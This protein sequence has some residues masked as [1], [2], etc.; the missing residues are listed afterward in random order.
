MVLDVQRL[1]REIAFEECL[2]YLQV[3]MEEHKFQPPMGEKTQSVLRA[4]LRNFSIGQAYNLIW[5]AARNAASFY[6]REQTSKVH[7]AN[8]VPGAIQRMA[9]R[10]LV[11]GW[12]LKPFRRDFRAPLSVISH[13]LFTV[14]LSLTDD[15]FTSVP[16]AENGASAGG[17]E[18]TAAG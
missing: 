9:E 16:P 2:K 7:A 14:A 12:D 1:H 17:D 13:V 5:R 11:E 18:R 15:G 10:S 8:T 3:V 4:V 6:L